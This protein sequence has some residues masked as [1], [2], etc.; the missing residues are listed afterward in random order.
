MHQHSGRKGGARF[1]C[2]NFEGGA[3]FQCVYFEGGKISVHGN[4]KIPPPP[5][6]QLIMTAPLQSPAKEDSIHIFSRNY[7][8]TFSYVSRNKLSR[9]REAGSPVK[10]ATRALTRHY[11]KR[12]NICSYTSRLSLDLAQLDEVTF[13]LPMTVYIHACTAV[14]F[15]Y[16]YGMKAM[17]E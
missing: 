15:M 1:Q 12:G 14:A 7:Y 4:L 5:W 11:H 3:S 6:H 10:P 16:V 8:S 2:A 13:L 17:N 9:A